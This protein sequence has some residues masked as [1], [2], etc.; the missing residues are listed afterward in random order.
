MTV[1]QAAMLNSPSIAVDIMVS[2]QSL[3]VGEDAD[4]DE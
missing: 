3:F 1:W 2:S 4:L